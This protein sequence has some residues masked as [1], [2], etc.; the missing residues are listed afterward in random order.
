MVF[1]S[2]KTTETENFDELWALG[3]PA[4]VEQ[5]FQE[6]LPE[7]ASSP[8][9]SMHL[10][11]L[12]QLALAQALQKKFADAHA[13]LDY[14][15]TLLTP[16]YELA[17]VR[18]LL[19]R[20]RVFQQAGDI[21]QARIFF[22]QSFALSAQHAFDY[23]TVN[24]AHMIAII[25]PTLEEKIIWNQRAIDLALKS[26]DKQA[27]NWLGS[28]YN[29]LGQNYMDSQQFQKAL[30]AFEEALAYRIQEKYAAN[31]RVAQWAIARAKRMLGR[32]DEAL[33]TQQ[34]L[35]K[36]FDSIAMQ[37]TYDIPM[38]LFTLTRGWVYEELAELY[39]LKM[40]HFA[41]LAHEDL[42]HDDMFNQ[43]GSERLKRLRQLARL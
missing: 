25:A 34:A 6:L 36:E 37:R 27:H 41:Q 10:Q 30:T 26:N 29:N 18:I 16:A 33:E 2:D 1:N 8:N 11:I 40:K 13:T 19:E 35:L 12:S 22:D 17:H 9:K 20:G 24:I 31:I 7:T 32:I 14:A 3:E 21:N 43:V 39:Y 23:H 15:E 5:R 4:I 38:E 42:C 28:L